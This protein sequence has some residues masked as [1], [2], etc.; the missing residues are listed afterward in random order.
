M[1]RRHSESL[2][3]RRGLRVRSA[4]AAGRLISFK[5]IARCPSA[6]PVPGGP[7][8]TTST[9]NGV[10]CV[11]Q[12]VSDELDGR[13]QHHVTPGTLN[14]V[15]ASA[16][17]AAAAER[18]DHP[19]CGITANKLAAFMLSIGFREVPY[20]VEIRPKVYKVLAEPA[21]S[22]MALARADT[23]RNT[24]ITSQAQRDR[25]KRLYSHDDP[26]LDPMRAH[27]HPAVGLWQLDDAGGSEPWVRLNHGERADTGLGANGVY[28]NVHKMAS[29]DSGGEVI[30]ARFARV[31]CEAGGGSAGDDA[32]R[33]NMA[34]GTWAACR[35]G[36]CFAAQFKEI[37][38]AAS[39]DLYVTI[40][41]NPGEY[42]TSG[43]VSRHRCH[44]DD[45][46]IGGRAAVSFECFF[47]DTTQP[48][49]W[50]PSA[51]PTENK[52]QR[53]PL[54]APFVAFTQ[55][56]GDI[57]KRFAVFPGAV[58]TELERPGGRGY[59]TYVKA[60]PRT[61]NPRKAEY[62]WSMMTA[63][64]T[65]LRVEICEEPEWVTSSPGSRRCISPS[66]VD[67]DFDVKSAIRSD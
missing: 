46:S 60:I 13:R 18:A 6:P 17:A 24:D 64:G 19:T 26:A 66:A 47:Y 32:V 4:S 38:L 37:Y 29:A 54:A 50:M 40:A 51:T 58:L 30:A 34:S 9:H 10:L 42:S 52:P 11:A 20:S 22:P 39:D 12:G 67:D 2:C 5:L 44:W 36:N 27:I 61:K 53:G 7:T 48:E 16:R 43:G 56:D 28:D 21:R 35:R 8:L 14:G 31:Y 1:A 33:R 57:E 59:G 45:G 15:L 65:V 62:P 23:Y 63:G 41:Q 49:G 3:K 25:N 55:P